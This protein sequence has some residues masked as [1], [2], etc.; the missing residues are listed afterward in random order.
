M[1]YNERGNSI[2]H[3]AA[4]HTH[5]PD[6]RWRPSGC[7]LRREHRSKW[8]DSEASGGCVEVD[9]AVDACAERPAPV[10]PEEVSMPLCVWP[11]SP[12]SAANDDDDEEDEDTNEE[13][14]EE[15]D[16]EASGVCESDQRRTVLSVAAVAM[17]HACGEWC[18]NPDCGWKTTSLMRS[19]CAASGWREETRARSNECAV[20]VQVRK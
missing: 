6:T 13:E 9:S 11:S 18:A 7:Q 17:L 19:E 20:H 5:L 4:A 14:E 10:E 12:P 2:K 8:P 15:E 1:R 3:E 16:D